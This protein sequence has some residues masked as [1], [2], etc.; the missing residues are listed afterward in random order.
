MITIG[1]AGFYVYNLEEGPISGRRRFNMVPA[2]FEAYV[3]K[4]TMEEIENQYRD[5]FLPYHDPNVQ[6]IKRVL[7]RLLPL[8]R[9]AGLHDVNWELHVI[10]DPN[11]Q[12]AFVIPGG[13]IFVFTGIL[14][15][16]KDEDGVAAVLG[17]E[18]AHVVAHHSAENLSRAPLILLGI[19]LLLMLDFSL[20]SSQLLLDVFLSWPG[21]RKQE[22]EADYIGLLMMAQGCYRPE[23]AMEFW[24]RME[25]HAQQA[26]PQ[27]LSTHPSSHNR[28]AKIREW[29]PEAIDKQNMSECHATMSYMDQFAATFREQGLG[30]W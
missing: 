17:H 14:P 25:K 15:L 9:E 21:S 29:L 23:A 20:F 11:Q 10:D 26:P 6:Q 4:M 16:C 30:R 5:R 7:E 24:G 22:S 13:K 19:G 18:I 27:L 1:S 8:A 3:G 12:N 2:S 28:E